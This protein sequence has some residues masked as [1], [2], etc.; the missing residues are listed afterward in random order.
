MVCIYSCVEE[1]GLVAFAV[2]G[3]LPLSVI[4]VVHL[5]NRMKNFLLP[6]E[7]PVKALFSGTPKKK[8]GFYGQ[9][10]Q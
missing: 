8:N 2:D 5:S 10:V 4:S 6:L 3:R 9:T 7:S 1:M